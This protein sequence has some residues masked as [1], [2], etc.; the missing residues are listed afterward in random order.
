[1]RVQSLSKSA[2]PFTHS[3]FYSKV[4]WIYSIPSEIITFTN[5]VYIDRL[6]EAC[7][8]SQQHEIRAIAK[9]GPHL[10]TSVHSGVAYGQSY[11]P[12]KETDFHRN[13]VGAILMFPSLLSGAF[14]MQLEE[15]MLPICVP[16]TGSL[17]MDWLC[18]F[19]V[20]CYPSTSK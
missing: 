11:S 6:S 8:I 17:M 10:K 15:S 4:G 12:N 5:E 13:G 20:F 2:M 19:F 1:M 14:F 3:K 7:S 18:E 16:Y 9:Y